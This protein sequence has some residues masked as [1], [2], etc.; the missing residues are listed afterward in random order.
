MKNKFSA[1]RERL[2]LTLLLDLWAMTGTAQFHPTDSMVYGTYIKNDVTVYYCSHQGVIVSVDVTGGLHVPEIA[3]FNESDSAFDF[4]PQK[5]KVS[6]YRMPTSASRFRHQVGV[7]RLR[8]AELKDMPIDTL[9]IYPYDT[10]LRHFKRRAF[11]SDILDNL[12]VTTT[13][14][15]DEGSQDVIGY[16]EQE[17]N[18]QRHLED[19]KRIDE[20]YWRTNTILPH[21]SHMG[22]IAIKKMRA[23]HLILDIPVNG[24]VCHFEILPKK[25]QQ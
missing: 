13:Y 14:S 9:S 20:G 24:I 16:M 2:L 22:F 4:D 25:Y 1:F 17:K 11:W 5:T 3:I 7:F 10:Y 19:M 6:V 21:T 8:R 15:G 23:D 12:L 18:D